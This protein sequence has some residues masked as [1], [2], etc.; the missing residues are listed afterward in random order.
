MST[1]GARGGARASEEGADLLND[2]WEGHDPRLA[3]VA[4]EYGVGLVCTHAGGQVPR[5][6]PH[7]VEYRDVVADI[8]ATT[9]ALA[10]RAVACGVPRESVIIDPGHDF[11]K[12]TPRPSPPQPPPTSSWPPGWP[13]LMSL[14]R[15]DFVG[16]TLDIAAPADRLLGTL[17][18]TAVTA[19]L[20]A[21]VGGSM[22][23]RPPARCWTWSPR[24]GR[25]TARAGSA[26]P[27]LTPDLR[28]ARLWSPE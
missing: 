28:A 8:V 4:G 26:R 23:L 20:G 2:A 18:A 24:S 11:G 19:W 1:R 25:P 6:R 21:R 14:S 27:R 16:E 13:V 7:R 22:T 15:K 17:A 5:T 3:E 9:Q 10:D 12:T